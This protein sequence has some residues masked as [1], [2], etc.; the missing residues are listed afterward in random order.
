MCKSVIRADTCGPMQVWALDVGPVK[1]GMSVI[2]IH[3]F[4]KVKVMIPIGIRRLFQ[5][6]DNIFGFEAIKWILVNKRSH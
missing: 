3:I 6:I 5:E 4:D 2:S 1:C